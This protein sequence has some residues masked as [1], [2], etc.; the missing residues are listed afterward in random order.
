MRL[1]SC[2]Y[3]EAV[4]QENMLLASFFGNENFLCGRKT[5]FFEHLIQLFFRWRD[6]LDI[7]MIFLPRAIG[8]SLERA[9]KVILSYKVSNS[10][11]ADSEVNMGSIGFDD[12]FRKI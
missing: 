10:L 4:L 5:G 7:R 3:K 1:L 2:F 12:D 8:L 6:V 9:H 11:D